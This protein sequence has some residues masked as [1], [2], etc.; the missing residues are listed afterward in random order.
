[1]CAHLPVDVRGRVPFRRR[2]PSATLSTVPAGSLGVLFDQE[3]GIVAYAPVL[4]LAF[5]GLAGMLRA[6]SHRRLAIVLSAASL[7]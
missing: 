4:L 1:M 7:Y 5:V 6:R 2:L 3:Y